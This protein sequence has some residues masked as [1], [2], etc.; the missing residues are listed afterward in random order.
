MK[1]ITGF[2]CVFVLLAGC[3]GD[4]KA[5]APPVA[6]PPPVVDVKEKEAGNVQAL[7]ERCAEC[8]G[9]DGVSHRNE[10]PFIAGQHEAYLLTAMES[11]LNGNRHFD[12]MKTALELVTLD[13]L[14]GLAQHYAQMSS[15]WNPPVE[16][17]APTQ[18]AASKQAVAA[19]KAV[20]KPCFGCHGEDGNTTL[21]G[22]PSLAG[23]Q[24]SY[25]QSALNAYLNGRRSDP[26]MVNFRHALQERDVKNLAAYFS[27]QSRVKSSLPVSGNA[28]RGKQAAKICVGCH[29]LDGNSVNPAMPSISGQ[30]ADYLVKAITAYRSGQRK[31]D[32]MQG[33][34]AKLDDKAI[35]NLAAYYAAQTPADG[36]QAAA[37]GAGFDPLGDGA[38]IAATCDG[39][40]GS[41]GNS[42]AAGTPSLTRQPVTYLAGAVRA[43][44]DGV[45]RHALMKGFVAALN[46]EDTEKVAFHYATQEPAIAKTPRKGDA[47]A[48]EAV[49]EGCKACHGEKGN[50][51]D[52]RIPAL[53]G[54]DAFYLQ[55]AI[56]A[57]AKG[58]RASEDMKSAVGELGKQ[59]ILDV[60]AYYAEQTPVKFETRLPEAPEVIAQR[61]NR[62]HGENGFSTDPTKPRLAG[63]V[64]SYLAK[65]LQDY[66]SGGR[67]S[68]AMHAMADVLSL[69]EIKAMAAYYSRQKK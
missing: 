8:H 48:G 1:K 32:L 36:G 67:E 13:D 3:G 16:Q 7:L 69:V 54:Q 30:N 41:N 55:Q 19:G 62:C 27:S 43:Y 64:A 63:Q 59:Q 2:L 15:P 26:I 68:S 23:L 46:D 52:A 65:S 53:A 10:A 25:L 35:A 24:P 11:Y 18:R 60:A 22:L 66:Q 28:E 21:P 38:R 39:C 47:K 50:S 49:A 20:A 42:E 57:Y 51:S 29:G 12:G 5:G 58:A 4:E 56:E 45:R 33:A 44:R 9:A 14:K 6:S 40:H 17:Q 61:C 37:S 34:V 31:S